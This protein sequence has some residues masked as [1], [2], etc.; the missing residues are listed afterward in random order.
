MTT[1]FTLIAGKPTIDKDPDAVLDYTLDFS[2]WCAA[3]A[4]TIISHTVAV[5]GVVRNSST[6]TTL[7]VTLWMSGGTVG[8]PA[9]ATVRVVTAAGR[10]DDR[11][12]YFR[13]RQ[14]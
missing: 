2:A 5:I 14:R 13:I 9:S 7:A 10:T 3:M 12:V 1:T 6:N 8:Q 11:T 4:D